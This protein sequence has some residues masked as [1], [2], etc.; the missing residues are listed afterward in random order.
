[1]LGMAIN[2][3]FQ[4]ACIPMREYISRNPAH[5]HTISVHIPVEGV[6]PVVEQKAAHKSAPKAVTDTPKADVQ[7]KPASYAAVLSTNPKPIVP[8][9]PVGKVVNAVLSAA[10]MVQGKMQWGPVVG[11][12]SM[13]MPTIKVKIDAGRQ[14]TISKNMNLDTGAFL[15]YISQV[16]YNRDFA[17]LKGTGGTPVKLAPL[18]IGMFNKGH[19]VITTMMQGVTLR[20]GCSLYSLDFM[21]VPDAQYDYLLGAPFMSA[22]AVKPN[23]RNEYAGPSRPSR[24]CPGT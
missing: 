15:N 2:P 14:G 23:F 22:F 6:E 10:S 21:V 8:A 11:T 12:W 7:K 18:E 20:I 17:W 1:M 24:R 4:D 5:V 13:S 16:A 9:A 3:E 19:S